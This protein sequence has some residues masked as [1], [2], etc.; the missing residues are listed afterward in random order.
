MKALLAELE[1]LEV[2]FANKVAKLRSEYDARK[3][4]LQAQLRGYLDSQP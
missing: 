4:E 3:A 1:G 2:D